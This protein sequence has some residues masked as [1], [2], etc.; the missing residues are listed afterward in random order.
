MTSKRFYEMPF[1]R[2]E[3][4]LHPIQA[5]E[6]RVGQVEMNKN[7]PTYESEVLNI[8]SYEFSIDDRAKSEKKIKRRLREKKLGAYDQ[9]RIDALRE[10]KDDVCNEL[11]KNIKSQFYAGAKG[12]YSDIQDWQFDR[13]LEHMKREHAKVPASA[14][15]SFLPFAIYIYY[16]R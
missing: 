6:G 15:D 3:I 5:S 1:T 8:L 4:P 10:F 16:L 11:C 13:L 7:Q 12:K 2:T 14:I 9:S